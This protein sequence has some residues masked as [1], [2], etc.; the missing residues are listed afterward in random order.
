MSPFFF[1]SFE[2]VSFFLFILFFLFECVS[3]D[4]HPATKAESMI[5]KWGIQTWTQSWGGGSQVG[6]GT[7]QSPQ[8]P[9]MEE[10]RVNPGAT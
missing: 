4:K 9:L 10:P 7:C 3:F 8:I 2:C 6:R 5:F 1:F